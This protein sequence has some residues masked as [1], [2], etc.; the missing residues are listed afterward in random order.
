[1]RKGEQE[2]YF[3]EWLEQHKGTLVKVT[4]SFANSPADFDDLYQEIL[5]QVWKSIPRFKN[6][7]SSVT[8]V[9]RVSLN[10]AIAWKKKEDKQRNLIR[11]L[12][13]TPF[14]ATPANDKAQRIEEI[15][16][17]IRS[18]D[19]ADRALIL[20]SLDGLSYEAISKIAEI[21]T[22]NVGVRLN[23]IRKKLSEHL[24]WD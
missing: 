1:M 11:I 20:M 3:R 17:A 2:H 12:A 9:Y 23:R 5:L 15:Y 21:S 14:E 10:R 22:S 4:R 19:K 13:E 16:V 6:E 8:W 24:K 18:L 7:S